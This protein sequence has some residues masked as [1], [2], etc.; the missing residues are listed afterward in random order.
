MS[1]ID[2][3][4]YTDGIS[5]LQL[6]S[7][8]HFKGNNNEYIIN[9]PSDEEFYIE[10]KATDNGYMSYSIYE[11]NAS[12]EI[13]RVINY[14]NI[15]L[16]KNDLFYSIIPKITEN[17]YSNTINK[18]ST[19]D[20]KLFTNETLLLA[21]DDLRGKSINEN[22]YTVETITN[23]NNGSAY[24]AGKFI[25][26]SFSRVYVIPTY[27]VKFLGWYHNNLLLTTNYEY[28]FPVLNDITLEARFDSIELYELIIT[29]GTGGSVPKDFRK[30]PSG[31]KIEIYAE[32][33][34]GYI[35]DKW[36]ISDGV[37]ESETCE[38]TILLCLILM[39][40]LMHFLN[41]FKIQT[42]QLIIL[43]I[44][45]MTLMSMIGIIML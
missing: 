40:Q 2:L 10:I 20:Y 39:L 37:L 11:I 25:K 21:N 13:K 29:A 8:P 15:E 18:G 4:T 9:L 14:S 7:L 24:G 19:V 35:F 34:D 36:V 30:F 3:N 32:A 26:G 23:N 22:Y 27:F 33:E 16:I 28:I 1:T 17:D 12:K 31:T 43:I 41:L 38:K 44:L 6:N 45:F 5:N 42:Y